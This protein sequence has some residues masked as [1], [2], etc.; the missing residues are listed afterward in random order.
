MSHEA[1]QELLSAYLDGELTAAE[2]A[3]VERLLA[4]DPAYRQLY[5]EL[6]ALRTNFETL[7]RFT[8]AK[9]ISSLVLR[10]A[11]QAMLHGTGPGQASARDGSKSADGSQ[12]RAGSANGSS[13]SDG[14]MT[15][16]VGSGMA[17]DEAGSTADEAESDV[18]VIRLRWP[19]GWRPWLWPAVAAAAALYVA[20][21]SPDRAPRKLAQAPPRDPADISIGAP[22]SDQP[23]EPLAEQELGKR[24][25]ELRAKKTSD[26][27][28][29]GPKP[30]EERAVDEKAVRQK[31]GEQAEKAA[32]A[33]Q[34]AR[35]LERAENQLE[36]RDAAERQ[37]MDGL[38]PAAPQLA[39]SASDKRTDRAPARK[40]AEAEESL[41]GVPAANAAA[42]VPAN[43]PVAAAK[44]APLENAAAPSDKTAPGNDFAGPANGAVADAKAAP[45]QPAA[46]PSV[47]V[48][49][50]ANAQRARFGQ[51]G[52]GALAPSPEGV[53]VVDCEVRPEAA[54]DGAFD[55]L[56]AKHKISLESGGGPMLAEAAAKK[57]EAPAAN[58]AEQAAPALLA[59]GPAPDQRGAG[60]PGAAP[61]PTAV[62][63]VYI[64]ASWPQIRALLVELNQRKEDFPI[65]QVM[66]AA[67]ARSQQQFAAFSRPARAPAGLAGQA[68][69]A[70]EQQAGAKDGGPQAP[71][72]AS[73][74]APAAG[75]AAAQG[76]I[77]E[78]E[79][80][81]AAADAGGS[82]SAAS[83]RDASPTDATAQAGKGNASQPAAAGAAPSATA[84]AAPANAAGDGAKGVAASEP[85]RGIAIQ[86][87][88]AP[89]QSNRA[90]PT[91]S[92]SNEPGAI[93]GQQ[94]Q[95][96]RGVIHFQSRPGSVIVV[97]GNQNVRALFVLRL[98]PATQAADQAAGARQPEPAAASLSPEPAKADPPSKP[99]PGVTSPEKG[100]AESAV[101]GKPEPEKAA[102]ESSPSQE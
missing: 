52:Q 79:R 7:P 9:D 98:A 44:P 45:Q 70:Q 46:M 65:V 21:F 63:P 22:A 38:V 43:A 97:P 74:Q 54:R 23:A 33:P 76:V 17:A 4:D 16:D 56:L 64:E 24:E 50:K 75:G 94:P 88:L 19:R 57:Q 69:V 59:A 87:N 101:P 12:Q 11:E 71:V 78:P 48:A 53:L 47:E 93:L 20:M 92:A 55:A 27:K 5:D 15:R 66:P 102:P 26:A 8:L 35:N 1:D 40:A 83:K 37:Q 42:A 14:R 62:V 73:P 13:R 49:G 18:P 81:V 6:R 60:K 32:A 72:M 29:A 3:R 100:A 39:G 68:L 80:P 95:P 91:L 2:Q 28:S 85:R 99:T 89:A 34:A 58:G 77:V 10:R 67:G 84:S 82:P 86:W 51:G 90:P 96:G 31:V 41:G 30:A 61:A 36:R 25:P